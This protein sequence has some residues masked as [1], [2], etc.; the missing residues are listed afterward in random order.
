[1]SKLGDL[2]S[3]RA[4]KFGDSIS[5]N[6]IASGG[7][8]G[9]QMTPAERQAA[10]KAGCLRSVRPEFAEGVQPGDIL[11]AGSNFGNGSSSPGAIEALQACGLQA[12]LAESVSRLMMRT[13]IAKAVPAFAAPGIGAIVEDGDEIAIDYGAG[14]VRNVKS[15]RQVQIRKFP[16]TVEQ[17]YDAG[18]IIAVIGKRLAEE[19]ILPPP[20]VAAS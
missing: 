19:G 8:G 12:I 17:I 9:G 5:T 15:G 7:R 20:A 14:M 4:W 13:C 10:I 18:G 16:A 6:Q 3:G 11:V 1:M 2:S